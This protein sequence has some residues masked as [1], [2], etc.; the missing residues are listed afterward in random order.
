L[1]ENPWYKEPKYV[2]GAVVVP[3][4]VAIIMI[5]PGILYPQP[6]SSPAINNSPQMK[7]D[8]NINISPIINN[9]QNMIA[10]GD[11][12]NAD[13]SLAIVRSNQP[14]SIDALDSAPSS[15]QTAG[16]TITWTAEAS[17][18]DNDKIYYQYLLNGNPVTGWERHNEWHWQTNEKYIGNNIIEVFV[19]DNNHAGPSGSDDHKSASFT[20]SQSPTTE[21]ETETTSSLPQQKSVYLSDLGAYRTENFCSVSYNTAANMKIGN[22]KYDNGIKIDAFYGDSYYYVYFNLNGEYSRLTGLVGFDD[23]NYFGRDVIVTFIGDGKDLL[24]INSMHPGDFPIKVDID[25]SGVHKLT[26]RGTEAEWSQKLDLI[27][28]ELTK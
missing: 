22:I 28:M 12:H 13:N 18:P 5:L 1:A 9:N 11:N 24:T 15:P 26:V 17:D 8:N 10:N 25:V 16:T 19:K 14:P 21:P 23:D 2:V 20:I 7:I 4:V 3:L 6:T 27:N